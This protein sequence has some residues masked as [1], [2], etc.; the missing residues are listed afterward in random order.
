MLD[1][2]RKLDSFF[3][4]VKL[5]A[6]GA[7]VYVC[8]MKTNVSRWSETAVEY[9]GLPD[10][11]MFDAG[12]IWAEHIHPS[13]R[14]EYLESIEKIFTGENASHE[15]MYRVRCADGSYSTCTCKGVVIRDEN[16]EPEFFCGVIRNN[17]SVNYIDP[18]T[19]LRSLYGFMDDIKGIVC[20]KSKNI[21]IML[22]LSSFSNI[23]DFYGYAFADRIIHFLSRKVCE[24]FPDDCKVYRMNGTRFAI[25]TNS[26]T[27]KEAEEIYNKL[28]LFLRKD[29]F[30]DNQRVVLSINGGAINV[31]KYDISWETYYS[32][33][34]LAYYQSKF[35]KCGSF[36][37][38]DDI[39]KFDNHQ[40]IERI[41][42]IRNSIAENFNGFYLCYQPIV[43]SKTEKIKAVEAL[44]RWKN[45]KFGVIPPNEFIEVLEQDALFPELGKWILR[46]AME[47]GK[48]FQ[49]KNPHISV[50]INLS[51]TQLEK[52]GFINDLFEIINYTKF[53][54]SHLCLEVT[55]RCRILDVDMLKNMFAIF[56]EKGIRIAVDDF[57]TGYSS[58]GF[59]RSVPVDIV[60]I[61]KDFVKNVKVNEA[62]K[63]SVQFISDLAGAFSAVVCAEGI[64]NEEIRDCI[65][66]YNNIDALQ[67][68]YYAKP[69]TAEKLLELLDD[70]NESFN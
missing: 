22:G 40:F 38:F 29:F 61:D 20:S 34:R 37:M 11:Y 17:N 49:K 70:E 68:Y 4:A 18:I 59:L 30:V 58:L 16:N 32:C 66:I 35:K 48:K 36:V 26:I 5:I 15:I 43:D 23:N 41:N 33:L 44:I 63:S 47:D 25:I 28:N 51:Y 10:K 39:I 24:I 2:K 46:Q 7:Y 52:N 56:R 65:K 42:A 55:E 53:P 27:Y 8:D 57:C 12:N 69:L 64:E 45:D 21:I 31:D 50:S 6:E 14:K 62:D 13:E 67:G 3:N 19:G 54:M 9:F 1:S 60:K